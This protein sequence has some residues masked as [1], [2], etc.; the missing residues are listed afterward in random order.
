MTIYE[1]SIILYTS[2]A[3]FFGARC[4]GNEQDSFKKIHAVTL[5]KKF[6]ILCCK[7]MYC[8]LSIFISLTKHRES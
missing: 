1:N 8:Y 7:Q 6:K 5:N 4:R 3:E 2:P